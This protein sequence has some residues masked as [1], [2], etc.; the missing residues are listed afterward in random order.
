MDLCNK[1]IS[2]FFVS[3]NKEQP[4]NESLEETI[5]NSIDTNSGFEIIF[6]PENDICRLRDI[7]YD[8]SQ[9]DISL[10]LNP[11]PQNS[12]CFPDRKSVE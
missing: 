7:Y 12:D 4:L 5:C 3:S 11:L 2:R 6:S 9:S 10:C 8:K 1:V